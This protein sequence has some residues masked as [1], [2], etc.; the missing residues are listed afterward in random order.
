MSWNINFP[1]T[2]GA[3]LATIIK[4]LSL[5]LSL[6]IDVYSEVSTTYGQGVSESRLFFM[7]KEPAKLNLGLKPHILVAEQIHKMK[8]SLLLIHVRYDYL[9]YKIL[10]FDTK[11]AFTCKSFDD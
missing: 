3:T 4:W 2:M 11:H 5:S 1:M 9:I 10:I 8:I 6:C 7:R